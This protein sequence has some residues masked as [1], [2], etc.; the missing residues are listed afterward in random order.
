MSSKGR[1]WTNCHIALFSSS[2]KKSGTLYI[3]TS[4]A[5][6]EMGGRARGKWAAVGRG[7]LCP[8]SWGLGPHVAQCRL[9]RGRLAPYHVAS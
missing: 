5:A 8:F 6:A 1:R 7:L 9:G 4:S 3:I 2:V